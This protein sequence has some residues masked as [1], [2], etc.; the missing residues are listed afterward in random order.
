MLRHFATRRLRRFAL[1]VVD[2]VDLRLD[3]L[4]FGEAVRQRRRQRCLGVDQACGLVNEFDSVSSH[5]QPRCGDRNEADHID[6][7]VGYVA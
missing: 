3:G 2:R 4:L 6:Q 1:D 5:G 7:D